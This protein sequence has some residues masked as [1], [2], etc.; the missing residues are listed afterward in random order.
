MNARDIKRRDTIING[1]NYLIN[2]WEVVWPR[3]QNSDE[4][5]SLTQISKFISVWLRVTK[6]NKFL[7]IRS[8]GFRRLSGCRES[9]NLYRLRSITDT[10]WCAKFLI[11][12]I[13]IFVQTLSFILLRKRTADVYRVI[14]MLIHIIHATVIYLTNENITWSSPLY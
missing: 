13:E 11:S 6:F 9:Y 3:K 8:Q 2:S 5:I 1:G 4:F 10:G 14:H 12:N 7:L